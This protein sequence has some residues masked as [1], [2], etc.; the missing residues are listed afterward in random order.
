MIYFNEE[1]DVGY[2][3]SEDGERVQVVRDN[4]LPGQA[5]VGRCNGLAVEFSLSDGQEPA[6]VEVSVIEDD[7]PRRARRRSSRR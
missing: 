7:N 5:P 6:A 3:R 1:K 2:I 4:F